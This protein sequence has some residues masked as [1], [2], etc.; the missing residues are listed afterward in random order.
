MTDAT[1]VWARCFVTRT[2]RWGTRRTSRSTIS[3]PSRPICRLCS[4]CAAREFTSIY[5]PGIG[6]RPRC[7]RETTFRLEDRMTLRAC[8]VAGVGAV[9][10]GACAA[11]QTSGGGGGGT[12]PSFAICSSY[13][14]HLTDCDRSRDE[15]TCTNACDNANAALLPKMRDD[16]KQLIADCVT[17]A[18]CKTM[19]D[20]GNLVLSR[21]TNEAA[22]AV[23][24]SSAASAFCDAYGDARTKCGGHAL[25]RAQCLNNA[26]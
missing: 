16:V 4:A 14:Q 26:K 20:D 8:I 24:A 21:C 12:G 9:L 7:P 5:V 10:V 23:P 6:Q 22:A 25:D 19:L 13:C 18:D 2:A 11:S 3:T 1:G 15:R 17:K